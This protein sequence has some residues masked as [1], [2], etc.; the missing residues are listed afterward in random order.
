[1]RIVKCLASLALS[2]L[3]FPSIAQDNPIVE[4][5]I[6]ILRNVRSMYGSNDY[7]SVINNIDLWLST[8][9]SNRQSLLTAEEI[10]FMRV[11]SE[12]RKDYVAGREGLVDFLEHYPASP[13]NNKI[14]AFAGVAAS[15]DGDDE[16]ALVFFNKCNPENLDLEC[17]RQV[18]LYNALSLIRTNRLEEGYVLLDVLDNLGGYDD[19]VLFYKSCVD[20]AQ[21][22]IETSKSG[23]TKLLRSDRFGAASTLY[24]AETALRQGNASDAERLSNVILEKEDDSYLLSEAERIL[25]EAYYAE[26]KWREADEML[27]SYVLGDTKPDRMDLYQ[28]GMSNWYLGDYERAVKFLGEISVNN[29]ALEQNAWFHM[30]LSF[31]KLGNLP[32]AILAF[33]QVASMTADKSLSEQ[34][35]YN[36]AMCVQ[37]SGYSPFAE[38]ITA[39]ERFL[40]EYP[41]S[42][43]TNQVNERLVEMYLQSN[44]YDAA[45]ASI[46]KINNPGR[47][48]LEAK[49]QLLFRKGVELY[50]GAEFDEAPKYLSQAVEMSQYDRQTA[51]EA[52]FWLAETSFRQGDYRQADSYYRRFTSLNSTT[53]SPLYGLALYGAGYAAYKSSDWSGALSKWTLLTDRYRSSVSG[54]VLGDAYARMGDCYFYQREYQK[55]ESLYANSLR[56]YPKNGDYAIYQ[57]GLCLGLRKDYTAKA[58]MLERIMSEYP[59]SAYCLQ[60]LYEQGRAYQQL[61]RTSDAI[62]VF[63][64]I[65]ASYPKSDLARKA[66]AETALM[67]YQDDEYDKA[68]P[69]YKKVV[70][71]YP[72]SEEALTAMRDLRS[73]YVET[74]RVDQYL[75]YAETITGAVPVAVDERDSLVYVSAERLFSRGDMDEAETALR[76][77]VT[78]YPEGAYSANANYYLGVIYEDRKEYQ[79][80]INSWLLAAKY[81]NSRFC[82]ESLDRAAQLSYS[83]K[84]YERAL[85][86]YI[87]LYERSNTVEHTR[88]SLLGI[89]RSAYEIED[90]N[91]VLKYADKALE[92][93]L[94]A[95][96]TTEIQ[97]IKG[98]S[99][100]SA[101]RIDEA[102]SIFRMLSSDTRSVYGAE[103]SFLVSQ[104]LYGKQ[105]LTA[106]ENNIM[107]LISGGTPHG[108]WLARSF[109]LLSDI[110]KDQGKT[111]EAR[112][113]LISLRQN[114]KESDEIADMIEERLSKLD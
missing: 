69:A 14:Y 91:A 55:A 97:Y 41:D 30:G 77:Y 90:R 110:Y 7:V 43:Y 37:E 38:P 44:S 12:V 21:G 3:W 48:L 93:R 96:Q 59:S 32:D 98:K 95:S 87:R 54:E 114:Y 72:G 58:L 27:T 88:N 29:D 1:M 109:I 57:T 81:E 6:R 67:Y 66:M 13:Y 99:L 63:D 89:V 40:N 73:I 52:C 92:Q 47:R 45:L 83:V 11:I 8:N 2:M 79:K 62:R 105:E 26:G 107:D 78:Q 94:D 23:F 68:I 25:G 28:L 106:A 42:R 82:T 46:E 80:A 102:L 101:G 100:L 103:S 34:A 104:L 17:C 61:D 36:Y 71:T 22:R 35:L 39:F 64:H 70:E 50:A 85:D 9:A 76:N 86:A 16:E 31:L 33:E 15:I 10:E 112:Q 5:D 75:Q 65:V 113:Y 20:Y 111:I 51:A 4:N 74:G 24:L 18:T 84:D 56:A 60:A 49:Q 53:S 108:Y 19:D